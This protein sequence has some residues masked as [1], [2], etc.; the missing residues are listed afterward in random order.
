MNSKLRTNLV[1]ALF[2][3]IVCSVLLTITFYG[4]WEHDRRACGVLRSSI[5]PENNTHGHID[6]YF[7]GDNKYNYQFDLTGLDRATL[8]DYPVTADEPNIIIFST[9]ED[10]LNNLLGY[11]GTIEG[12]YDGKYS[13]CYISF[14]TITTIHNITNTED[15]SKSIDDFREFLKTVG[16]E[17]AEQERYDFPLINQTNQINQTNS[18]N[19]T[20]TP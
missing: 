16:I 10:F 15:K 17:G 4:I 13:R 1:V 18:I 9:K 14:P 5:Y 7:T 19:Q 8:E 2:L 11:Q 12:I 20:K 6:L 3:I